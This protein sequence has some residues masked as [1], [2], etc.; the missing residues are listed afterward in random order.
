MHRDVENLRYLCLNDF[1][2][3]LS[4]MYT[5]RQFSKIR[6]KWLTAFDG[7]EGHGG[8][9]SKGGG[10]SVDG[11]SEVGRFKGLF[12]RFSVILL[13]STLLCAHPNLCN[14]SHAKRTDL[15]VTELV[16]WVLVI[17][18]IMLSVPPLCLHVLGKQLTGGLSLARNRTR[19][20]FH[21]ISHPFPFPRSRSRLG[22]GTLWT[23]S[24]SVAT[25]R[26]D[27]DGQRFDEKGSL[28]HVLR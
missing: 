12:G 27:G 17:L 3:A 22:R 6:Q 19:W 2:A 14:H 26:D 9:D 8:S 21:L 24:R 23:L 7:D 11:R 5:G 15:A 13:C 10:R 18:V 25:Q 28:A 16:T 20:I 4:A 1:N